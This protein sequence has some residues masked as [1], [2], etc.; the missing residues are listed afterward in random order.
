VFR[1][2]KPHAIR[3][4]IA[5]VVVFAVEVASRWLFT[6]FIEK[7]L[8]GKPA[9]VVYP[10]TAPSVVFVGFTSRIAAT[11]DHR[12]PSLVRACSRQPVLGRHVT[13]EATTRPRVAYPQSLTWNDLPRTAIAQTEPKHTPPAIAALR[14]YDAQSTEAASGSN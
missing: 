10:D 12:G 4:R 3:F 5:L 13:S 8:E 14:L 2:R 6:H 1:V 7:V 11:V 9:R